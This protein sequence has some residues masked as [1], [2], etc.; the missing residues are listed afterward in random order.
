M[1]RPLTDFMANLHRNG[2]DEKRL[3]KYARVRL[4]GDLVSVHACFPDDG[5]YGLDL[6]TREKEPLVGVAISNGGTA[7]V[8]GGKAQSSGAPN[9]VVNGGGASV[10]HSAA[11]QGSNGSANVDQRQLLTHCCKYLIN[12]TSTTRR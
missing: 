6:Y 10:Q 1:T 5:Q 2:A 7:I 9:G 3:Q 12:V 4:H 8:N 11:A